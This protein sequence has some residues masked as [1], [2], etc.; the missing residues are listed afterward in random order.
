M[1]KH[2]RIEVENAVVKL[3]T[4]MVNNTLSNSKNWK[5]AD[6]NNK[7]L[8]SDFLDEFFPDVK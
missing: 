4:D 5:L 6:T 7:K 2:T 8:V 3:A 1:S